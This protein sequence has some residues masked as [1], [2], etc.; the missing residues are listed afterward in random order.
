MDGSSCSPVAEQQTPCNGVSVAEQQKPCIEVSVEEQQTLCNEV[1]VG[2]N[3]VP[4][5]EKKVPV[6][7]KKVPINEKEVPVDEKP[8]KMTDTGEE[9]L[10]LV[11]VNKR[12]DAI[13]GSI[14]TII[15]V[16]VEAAVQ[17]GP[18]SPAALLVARERALDDDDDD[19][20]DD[21]RVVEPP[22]TVTT[23]PSKDSRS[24]QLESRLQPLYVTER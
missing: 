21:H 5:D 19:Y 13:L 8:H 24:E 15:Q 17:E 11:G 14:Q 23:V 12:V 1:S 3:E 4:V 2:E 16:A 22:T 20:G 7:V 9:E 18:L 10:T 6:D